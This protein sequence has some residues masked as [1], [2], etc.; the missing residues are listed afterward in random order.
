MPKSYR[1]E[2]ENS[3]GNFP[4]GTAAPVLDARASRILDDGGGRSNDRPRG[5]AYGKRNRGDGGEGWNARKKR[6]G[7]FI[8]HSSIDGI[9]ATPGVW[10][11]YCSMTVSSS[12]SMGARWRASGPCAAPAIAILS[13]VAGVV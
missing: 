13:A 10:P 3:V 1:A 6:S 12:V 2:T 8:R 5:S 9:G 11:S 7:P 4:Y